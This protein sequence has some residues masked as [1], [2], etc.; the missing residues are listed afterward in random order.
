C[1]TCK[2][3]FEKISKPRCKRCFRTLFTKQCPDCK[4]WERY[5][6]G[7]DPLIKNV[8]LFQYN[9]AMKEFMTRWKYRGD[10]AIGEVFR[11]TF[12]SSFL[13]HFPKGKKRYN[14]VPIPLSEERR[15]E[16]AFNQAYLLA[17]Y[18]TSKPFECLERVN[19]EKQAKKT[20][21][22]RLMTKNPFILTESVTKP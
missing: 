20:R 8:S 9:D 22:E 10:Y 5:Y 15:K 2:E 3:K 4:K 12:K 16:R 14:I 1:Q 19:S 11:E 17:S 18:L 6:K 21:Y 13:K 7:E